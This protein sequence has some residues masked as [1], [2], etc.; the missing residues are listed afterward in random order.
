M[1]KKKIGECYLCGE[2]QVLTKD[3]VPPK[4]FFPKPINVKN[5]ITVLCCQSCNQYWHIKE[6]KLAQDLSI[7]GSTEDA[8]KIFKQCTQAN[9]L[10]GYI[11]RGGFPSKEYYDLITRIK[12]T[13]IKTSSGIILSKPIFLLNIPKDRDEVFIK[14]AKGLHRH[15]KGK[16]LPNTA[17]SVVLI[18]KPKNRDVFLSPI[19]ET[20]TV[21]VKQEFG[22]TFLYLGLFAKDNEDSTLWYMSFYKNINVLV[23]LSP[24]ITKR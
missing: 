17:R 15:H 24:F 10:R 12:K 16:R 6:T 11:T 20:K 19:K 4:V 9:Y 13:Y 5:L 1:K 14:I 18:E 21:S 7:V 23:I 2:I 8:Y 22:D 3:H